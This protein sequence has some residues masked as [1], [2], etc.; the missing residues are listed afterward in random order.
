MLNNFW[1]CINAVIPLL[2]YLIIGF[3]IRRTG[4]INEDEVHR[5]N[6]LVFVVCFPAMMFDNLYG[7]DIKTAFNLKLVA[8]ALIFLFAYIGISIPLVSSI[9][10]KPESRGAMI[11]AMYR[12]N[13]VLMGLP[14]AI[15]IY[16]KGNVSVTAFLIAFVVPAYNVLAVIILEYYRGGKTSVTKMITK[17]IKN[18]IILGAVMA[19]IVISLGIKLPHAVDGVVAAMSDATTPMAMILLGTSFNIRSVKTSKRNLCIAVIAKLLIM[20]GIG[21]ALAVFLGFRNIEFVSLICM[22]AAPCAVSSYT[23]AESMGSDGE[24][25]GNAVIFTTALSVF[26]IFAWL[27]LFKTLGIF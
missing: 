22:M 15:N 16:G 18:P 20:P 21:L 19:V 4:V 8:F 11:Q 3:A 17:I 26:T 2:I 13:Y 9:E 24:L 7:A 1:I 5:F 10:K 12:S 27:F 25:A 6:H 14:I 23:M